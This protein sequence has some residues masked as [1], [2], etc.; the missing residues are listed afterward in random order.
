[1]WPFK[2]K[3]QRLILPRYTKDVW[4]KLNMGSSDEWATLMA[5]NNVTDFIK[6]NVVR[7]V[8]KRTKKPKY[9]SA[10]IATIDDDYCK[11]LGDRKHS[12]KRVLQY[13]LSNDDIQLWSAK[14]QNS[15]MVNSYN[16][17]NVP[18]SIIPCKQENNK[19]SFT[20]D[21]NTTAQI[22][23]ALQNTYQSRDI[24]CPGWILKGYDAPLCINDIISLA[25]AYWYE[26][27]NVTIGKYSEQIYKDVESK[28]KF[29]P[30]LF[31]VPFVIRTNIDSALINL[32]GQYDKNEKTSHAMT[33][34]TFSNVDK[35]TMFE[36][37]KSK[38]DLIMGVGDSAI[39]PGQAHLAYVEN[40]EKLETQRKTFS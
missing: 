35:L 27:K 8:K 13:I 10:L 37:F 31:V 5:P 32:S 12:E 22:I 28:N 17:L 1:M 20:L 39:M 38:I 2:Q 26:N 7:I 16:V 40:V 23:Q 11:W 36:A 29:A 19:T 14:L 34:I 4:L 6:T 9:T 3:P 24:F 30:H 18:L 33:F 25:E 15:G 21:K